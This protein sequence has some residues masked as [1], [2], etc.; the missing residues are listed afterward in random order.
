MVDRAY[1]VQ[2]CLGT[3]GK[4]V[5]PNEEEARVVQRRA[6]RFAR[7]LTR[8]ETLTRRDLAV[9]RPCRDGDVDASR[10]NDVLGRVLTVDVEADEVLKWE[11][12][13]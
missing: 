10:V 12:L 3:G 4:V 8:G 9:L 2:E 7:P 11:L 5:E 13:R 1:D 6:I